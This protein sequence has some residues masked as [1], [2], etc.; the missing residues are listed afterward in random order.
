M[1]S[2]RYAVTRENAVPPQLKMETAIDS[3]SRDFLVST[4]EAAAISAMVNDKADENNEPADEDEET[5]QPIA[6]VKSAD[7][8]D[9][10]GDGLI[11]FK[12][13]EKSNQVKK[14]NAYVKTVYIDNKDEIL[15][16]AQEA[17]KSRPLSSAEELLA[18]TLLHE[19]LH[20]L[21][22]AGTLR[23]TSLSYYLKKNREDAPRYPC[24]A[25]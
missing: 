7:Y 8:I 13:R 18:Q 3:V 24:L 25:W 6:A 9:M 20:L 19:R 1:L 16:E 11:D 2:S 4:E 17:L 5:E 10:W 14:E 15:R 23:H 12:A 21:Y 22:E